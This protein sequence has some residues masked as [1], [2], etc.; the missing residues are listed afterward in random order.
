MDHAGIGATHINHLLTSMNI[1]AVGAKT[2]QV[3]EKEIGP[4]VEAV[5]RESCQIAAREK[6]DKTPTSQGGITMSYDMDGK[7]EGAQ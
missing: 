6:M 5:V 1:P 2:E 7:K 3:R 4:V